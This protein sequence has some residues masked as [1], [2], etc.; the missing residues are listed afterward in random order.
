M[1]PQPRRGAGLA[2]RGEPAV[3]LGQLRPAHRP[4]GLAQ[5]AGDAPV[6]RIDL[7]R[8]LI[9]AAAQLHGRPARVVVLP[10]R[11]RRRVDGEQRPGLDPR[12][13]HASHLRED[14]AHER[15]M[16]R[17][18]EVDRE[19]RQG[20]RR[21]TGVE[22]E[23]DEPNRRID[24]AGPDE[25][26]H[27]LRGELRPPRRD[28][29]AQ[30]NPRPVLVPQASERAGPAAER[31]DR[32]VAR[33]P[34]AGLLPHPQ[35]RALEL[36]ERPRA[37][38]EH[39]AD[40]AVQGVPLAPQLPHHALVELLDARLEQTASHL[41]ARGVLKLHHE[42]R[43]ALGQLVHIERRGD[44]ERPGPLG[45]LPWLDRQGGRGY[46]GGIPQRREERPVRR[47]AGRDHLEP[48]SAQGAE[49]VGDAARL[50]L[51]ETRDVVDGDQGP[52]LD[53]L[54]LPDLLEQVAQLVLRHAPRVDELHAAALRVRPHRRRVLEQQ[55]RLPEP[56]RGAHERDAR[57]TRLER[58]LPQQPLAPHRQPRLDPHGRRVESLDPVP[59]PRRFDGLRSIRHLRSLPTL[60]VLAS[61]DI[62]GR[63]GRERGSPPFPRAGKT[64]VSRHP[65]SGEGLPTGALGT[66]RPRTAPSIPSHRSPSDCGAA[67][68]R[69]G[70]AQHTVQRIF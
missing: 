31:E 26:A 14:P 3:E 10:R 40:D 65:D 27:R 61:N 28:I 52:G 19:L 34:R 62:E 16:P 12:G 7:L 39:Q 45:V 59:A 49:Q 36:L 51:L 46:L 41:G 4:P 44:G 67:R 48:A 68:V 8:D 64:P 37:H 69:F 70:K 13:R 2:L 38:E 17:E 35:P 43:D 15:R 33:Q 63:P 25:Q 20:A 29:A 55:G 58:E 30:A 56:L 53:R 21:R 57:L 32:V 50:L 18:R 1:R 9:G 47:Q 22:D 23:S 42:R 54:P 60:E 6:R 5:G 11:Q 66:A 24:P